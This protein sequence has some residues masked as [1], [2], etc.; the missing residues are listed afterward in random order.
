M[1]RIWWWKL[2][3]MVSWHD[4][5]TTVGWTLVVRNVR[6]THAEKWKKWKWRTAFKVTLLQTNCCRGTVR[7]WKWQLIGTGY[8]TAMQASGSPLPALTDFG[9]TVMQ[10]DRHTMPKSATV[11]LHPVAY[12]RY[13]LLL[14]SRPTEGTRLSWPLF[15]AAKHHQILAGTKLYCLVT[16]AHVCQQLA[17]GCTRQWGGWDSNPRPIDRKSSNLPLRHQATQSIKS[18][19]G[20]QVGR[21]WPAGAKSNWPVNFAMKSITEKDV[22]GREIRQW[23]HAINMPRVSWMKDSSWNKLLSE[24]DC[25]QQKTRHIM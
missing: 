22:N 19:P 24:I 8:S 7:P 16:E 21:P 1:E 23:M 4:Q 3:A 14:I 13:K 5:L 9:P 6:C 15:P 18:I 25:R 12:T 2:A 20:A 11:G 10:P 17:Q